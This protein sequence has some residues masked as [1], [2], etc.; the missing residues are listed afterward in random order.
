MCFSLAEPA[1][2]LNAQELATFGCTISVT[3]N[4]H[5]DRVAS[6]LWTEFA[7]I[8]LVDEDVSTTR[9][10]CLE[11][12]YGLIGLAHRADFDPRLDLFIGRQLEHSLLVAGAAYTRAC[13]SF[14]TKDQ[15][16]RVDGNLCLRSSD[17]DQSS[18]GCQHSDIVVER[19]LDL[20]YQQL[21]ILSLGTFHTPQ[22]RRPH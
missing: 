9:R 12:E 18:V 11:I 22:L 6:P 7:S 13:D 10:T 16:K 1:S 14:A 20:K 3:M 8:S 5:P 19:R 17:L 4:H 2:C 15:A 21:I